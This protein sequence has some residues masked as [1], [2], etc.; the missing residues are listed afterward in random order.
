MLFNSFTFIVFFITVSI[1]YFII[2]HSVRWVLLLA[3]SFVFYMA[4]NPYL[5]VL[6]LFTIFVNYFSALRIYSE[7]RKR[8]KKRILIFSML[9]D[10][11]LLFIFKYLGFMNDTLLAL[12]GNNWP[13]ETLN[14]ILPMGISF[15]TFQAASYTIDVYRGDI[16]PER[17]F[18]IFALFVMF[19]PQLVAGPIER[20]R[21]LLPQF[22]EKH[23]FDAHRV[24]SGIRIM[25][26]GFFKKIV[27]ADRA[28]IAVNTIYNSAFDYKGLYL[29]AATVLFAFQI[30]CDFSGYSDIA[31]GCARVLGFDLM[32]NFKNPYLSKSI[33]EFWRRWHISLSTWFMDYVYI[34]LGGNREGEAKKYRNL[35]ITFLVS[36]LWHGAN[37]T[38]VLWG[39]LHGIYQVIGQLTLG[40]RRRVKKLLHL[41]DNKIGG[42]ISVIIT[43]GLVCFGWIFFRA[44]TASDAAYII[45]NIGAGFTGWWDRQYI[46]EVLTGM[47][48][49]LF[50]VL[51][52][53]AAILF[54]VVSEIACGRNC[55]YDVIERKNAAVRIAFFLITAVFILAAGVFYEA[56]AFIYFQF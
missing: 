47:G 5:I 42:L 18:G 49:N 35:L 1:L 37:W 19:F 25:L 16:K 51:V 12:F 24:V 55:V 30:Y 6:I 56:G 27:I 45:R 21:N 26:W 3:A 22:Y 38:F 48:L 52:T 43:F 31:K 15:Y 46:F 11:G 14:I 40:M 44:N 41:Y 29:T 53:G 7:K 54:L 20:S 2:P 32:D 17:H 34:P 10:F 9:V 36:G 50:E 8:H 33:K 28:A 13:V 23:G 4:W 39:G